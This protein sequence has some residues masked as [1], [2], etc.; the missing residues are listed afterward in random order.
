MTI[1]FKMRFRQDSVPFNMTTDITL[2]SYIGIQKRISSKNDYY[3][4]F[5]LTLGLS[6]INV[7]NNETSNVNTSGSS[8]V[9]PGW[10]GSLGIAFDLDGFNLGFVCGLDYASGV[11]DNWLYNGKLWISFA[12]GY[13]FF[14]GK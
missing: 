6:Y 7:G 12:I 9:V 13:A 2:G 5:P 1:P 4:T 14:Q 11:G 8:S 10:T 3:L